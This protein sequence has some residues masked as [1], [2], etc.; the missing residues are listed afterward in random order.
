MTNLYQLELNERHYVELPHLTHHISC[1]SPFE[2]YQNYLYRC[3]PLQRVQVFPVIVNSAKNET[4][5]GT[6]NFVTI[7]PSNL[8]QLN[9]IFSIEDH[10]DS[11]TFCQSTSNLQR[12]AQVRQSSLQ[13][14][15][16]QNLAS[17]T[18]RNVDQSTIV[19]SCL[20][21]TH[22]DYT[23]DPPMANESRFLAH[24]EPVNPTISLFLP[25]VFVKQVVSLSEEETL[26]APLKR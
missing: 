22:G 16:E 19:N 17:D 23:S 8:T 21:C 6:I 3:I 1:V 12:S 24:R 4:S 20:Y 5:K 9:Y 25:S 11:D 7:F 10:I 2:I 13:L 14:V 18:Y 26:Y 15:F